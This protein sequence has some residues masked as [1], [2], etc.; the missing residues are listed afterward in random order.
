M[1]PWLVY[2]KQKNGGYC[3]PCVVFASTGYQGSTPG[4][5]VSRPLT[6]LNKALELLR[7]HADKEHHRA[8]VVG[9]DEF[10]KTMSNQQ[11]SIQSQLNQALADRVAINRQKLESIMKTVVL[12]CRQNIAMRG[13]RDSA[14]DLER[15]LSG[16]VNHGNFLALLNF[17][18]EAG[19]TVLG[20]HLSTA[21]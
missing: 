8:A 5:L 11:P 15:D 20:E 6:T 16:S 13:H 19:D 12:C 1:F 9:A 10:K 17:R 18:V 4:V 21:A 14:P 2:N 7:K 3:L